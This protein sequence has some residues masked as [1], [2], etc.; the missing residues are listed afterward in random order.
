MGH[1]VIKLTL[2]PMRLPDDFAALR[3]RY[4]AEVMW[5]I[6]Q[7]PEGDVVTAREMEISG[8][9]DDLIWIKSTK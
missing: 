4:Q 9:I 5:W 8:K 3:A 6:R 7:L 2:Q 1:T